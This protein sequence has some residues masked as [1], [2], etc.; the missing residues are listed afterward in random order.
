MEISTTDRGLLL[1]GAVVMSGAGL[2][3]YD[4]G[5]LVVRGDRIE[6]IGPQFELE[7][8][9][10][11]LAQLDL[12][13][14][15]IAPGMINAHTH[16]SM[17]FFRG[18]G[19]AV[20]GRP[21]AADTMI[22]R[23]FYPAER[24]LSP[25]LIEPLAYS[26]LY[27][28]L[29]SGVTTIGDA[30]F[31]ADGVA[32]ACERLGIRAFIGEHIADLGGPV[33]AGK[34]RWL[35]TMKWI[36][37]WPYSLR[38]QP[39]VYAHAADTVSAPLLQRLGDYAKQN[40][41]SFHM[42]L[43]QSEGEYQRV[44]Q[45]EGISP[46]EYAAKAGVLGPRSLVVHL[47]SARA[48]DLARL[49]DSGAHAVICPVSEMIYEKLPDLAALNE[50]DIP[51]CIATDSPASNDGGRL[52]EEARL[53]ALLLKDRGLAP[54]SYAASRI[55]AAVMEKPARAYGRPDLGTLQA[56]CKADLVCYEGDLGSLPLSHPAETLLYSMDSRQV[57]HVMVD[58]EWLLWQRRLTRVREEDLRQSY[59]AAA[60]EI[61][62][63]TGLDLISKA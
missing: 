3:C 58:G 7:Q 59:M 62:K 19:H 49:Q 14:C 4:P 12:G 29:R 40:Q 24:A 21:S 17:G 23:F 13:G 32:K 2:A 53:Y 44:Q 47:L 45:R 16:S 25:E 6:A 43:S 9:Y 11:K 1:K 15:L 38:V 37:A 61:K 28:N 39:M 46:V 36:D 41:L 31:Y 22:E 60:T 51:I 26:Y 54:Q 52:L 5:A 20:A 63:R 35:K 48:D 57:A 56:G 34:D 30:Y 50:K 27:D 10:S 8:R 33:A 55:L 18:L 42:H